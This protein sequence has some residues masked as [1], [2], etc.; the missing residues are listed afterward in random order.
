MG[1]WVCGCVGVCVCVPL[2]FIGGGHADIR[3]IRLC[4][5]VGG[6]MYEK[7]GVFVYVRLCV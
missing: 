7:S 2:H 3:I 1:V 6:C 5:C 4:E